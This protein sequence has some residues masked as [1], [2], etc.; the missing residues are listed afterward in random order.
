MIVAA[1]VRQADFKFIFFLYEL[2]PNGLQVVHV[3]NLQ[4]CD[5]GLESPF[6]RTMGGVIRR[7]YYILS[8]C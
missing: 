2:C 6:Q 7:Q 4:C 8:F 3:V 5:S 1:Y